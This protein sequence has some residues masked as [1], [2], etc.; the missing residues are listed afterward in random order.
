MATVPREHQWQ[1]RLV[2]PQTH[3]KRGCKKKVLTKN[4]SSTAQSQK[5]MK[6]KK[7]TGCALEVRDALT[8]SEENDVVPMRPCVV[9]RK[10][11][12]TRVLWSALDDTWVC[13]LMP[14][15]PREMVTLWLC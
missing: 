12:L 1:T 5:T 15:R 2:P 11:L 7:N 6:K 9:G 13:D 4:A 10:T 3:G 14:R 8:I